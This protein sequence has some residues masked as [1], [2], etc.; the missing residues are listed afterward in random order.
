MQKGQSTHS[1][2]RKGKAFNRKDEAFKKN[3]NKAWKPW[4]FQNA[5]RPE[6]ESRR[7]LTLK[8]NGWQEAGSSVGSVGTSTC[9]LNNLRVI[10]SFLWT[11]L[12]RHQV[13]ID[14]K[15]QSS[16]RF[17]QQNGLIW[18]QQRTAIGYMQSMENHRRVWRT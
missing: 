15:Q 4:K 16:Q 1:T 14:L 12:L 6:F 3:L 18:E 11:P 13:I 10:R 8:L 7:K 17:Y 2:H 9:L 5:K